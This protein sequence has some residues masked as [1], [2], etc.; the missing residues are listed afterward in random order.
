MYLDMD[1]NTWN[2]LLI[3]LVHITRS[4]LKGDHQN[5]SSLASNVTQPLIQTLIVAW[6]KASLYAAVSTELWNDMLQ[7]MCF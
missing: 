3:I 1:D 4:L 6:I 2:Q 5:G 7:V